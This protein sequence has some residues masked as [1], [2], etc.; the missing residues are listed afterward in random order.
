MF[1]SGMQAAERVSPLSVLVRGAIERW[2]APEI[3]AEIAREGDCD[4]YERKITLEALTAIM[5]DAVVGMQ[6]SVHAAA[7]ARREQWLGSL[8]AF[9]TKLGRVDP[10]FSA[11]LVRHT[12]A[13]IA[14]LLC[15]A[16]RGKRPAYAVKILDG[17]MPDGSEHRLGVLREL[18]AAGLPG[19]AVVVYDLATGLCERAALAEDAY[20]AEKS[21][22]ERLL[23]EACPGELYVGDRGFCTVRLLGRIL[24]RGAAFVIRELAYDMVYEEEGPAR[25]R[26]R[27][28]TGAVDEAQVRLVCRE[29]GCAWALRRIHVRLDEPTRKGDREIR[30]LTNLPATYK[31]RDVAELYRRRWDVERHFQLIKHELH[32][33]LP[34]LGEPRAALFALAAAL[35]AGNVLA[36]IK[37][38]VRGCCGEADSPLA[39]SG[40]YLA[41]E[42]GRGYAAVETLTDDDDWRVVAALSAARFQSWAV[43]L[44]RAVDWSRYVTHPRGPKQRPPP[45]LR[46]RR[47][48]HSTYRLQH[49]QTH[50]G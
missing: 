39:L 50:D 4:N 18:R 35:A 45:K 42:I 12:A 28:S 22:A 10:R 32:G 49:P 36:W 7:L 48:H 34:S 31:A 47:H 40:Y 14:E 46:E 19:K 13:G 9:Y 29:R 21:L 6:P 1:I 33:E 44:I 27:C 41:L 8:Q 17:T 25:P 26:G 2:L 38:L 30:L 37:C 11:G 20:A 23:E 5:L 15:S 43:R 16:R 24:D 3:L